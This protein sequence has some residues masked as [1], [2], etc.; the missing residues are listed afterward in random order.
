MTSLLVK[1]LN[2]NLNYLILHHEVQSPKTREWFEEEDEEK[3]G[4]KG[5]FSLS[6]SVITKTQ[7]H[8]HCS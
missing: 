6:T 3:K 8:T 4:A 7:T 2:L 5:I 1:N